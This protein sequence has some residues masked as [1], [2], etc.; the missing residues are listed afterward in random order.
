MCHSKWMLTFSW[1]G[2]RVQ[3]HNI[4]V[5]L[6]LKLNYDDAILEYK[7]LGQQEDDSD[8]HDVASDICVTTFEQIPLLIK[9]YLYIAAV[10]IM[11][12]NSLSTRSGHFLRSK[13]Q[14]DATGANFK[15]SVFQGA[16]TY[17]KG[18]EKLWL[19][20]QTKWANLKTLYYAVLEIKNASG[21][22]WSDMD[23]VGIT[24]EYE[25]TWGSFVKSHKATKP[26]KNK[27]FPHFEIIHQMM[28]RKSRGNWVH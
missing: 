13:G 7:D 11:G 26:F 19:T 17:L 16:I 23:G 24:L 14:G 21:F 12:S 2:E 25:S 8:L 1:A 22:S 5:P 18:R 27:G 6:W 3:K 10:G 28:L 20:C 15:K 9:A 4:F